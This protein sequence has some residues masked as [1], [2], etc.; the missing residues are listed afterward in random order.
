M[1]S[2]LKNPEISEY[3]FTNIIEYI[4]IWDENLQVIFAQTLEKIYSNSN[5]VEIFS[6][7]ERV[8]NLIIKFCMKIISTDDNK[9][10]RL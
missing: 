5:K 4:E 6:N 7:L 1:L 3:I 8:H 9:V 2:Y 10:I